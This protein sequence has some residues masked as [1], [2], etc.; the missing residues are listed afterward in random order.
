M[1]VRLDYSS[2]GLCR[3]EMSSCAA[4]KLSASI[5][6]F[7]SDAGLSLVGEA[8]VY[9]SDGGPV[10]LFGEDDGFEVDGVTGGLK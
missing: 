7:G 4:Q 1:Q 6:L 2:V 3:V 9:R 10:W 5:Q 8:E